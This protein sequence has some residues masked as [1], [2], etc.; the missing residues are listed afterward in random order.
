MMCYESKAIGPIGYTSSI[1]SG[2]FNSI[3]SGC[4]YQ[5]WVLLLVLSPSIGPLLAEWAFS[6]GRFISDSSETWKRACVVS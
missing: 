2:C 3:R 4:F 6:D 5:F 1:G